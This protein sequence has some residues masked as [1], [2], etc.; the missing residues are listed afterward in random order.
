MD[1]KKL[2]KKKIS[3]W[4]DGDTFI[5]KIDNVSEEYQEYEDK[6]LALIYKNDYT[7]FLGKNTKTFYVKYIDS[8][9]KPQIISFYSYGSKNS[10]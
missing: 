4:V 5:V 1:T 10:L 7:E 6:Y 2:D 8:Y 9:E 3:N